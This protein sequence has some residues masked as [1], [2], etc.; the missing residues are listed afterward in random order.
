MDSLI[1][2]TLVFQPPGWVRSIGIPVRPVQK[3]AIFIPFVLAAEHNRIAFTET[4]DSGGKIN[5]V[6]DQ[7]GLPI[8]QLYYE[9]LMPAAAV[10][11]RQ[12]LDHDTLSRDLKVTNPVCKCI[13]KYRIRIIRALDRSLLW[14]C[15]VFDSL[16]GVT[17][18]WLLK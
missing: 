7:Q 1:C 10:V 16:L 2:L 15:A 4:A 18:C 12:Q 9:L 11:I 3:T 14:L 8:G 5:I 13:R 17:L 6:C